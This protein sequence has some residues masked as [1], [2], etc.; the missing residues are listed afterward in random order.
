MISLPTQRWSTR[1]QGVS[2]IDFFKDEL[3]DDE[4][5]VL[6][7]AASLHV[8]YIAYGTP[9]G[10]TCLV[11]ETRWITQYALD[12]F[13][14]SLEGEWG[15][16]YPA[17]CPARILKLLTPIE[18]L[19]EDEYKARRAADWRARCEAELERRKK[20]PKVPRGALVRF[21]PP[22][23]TKSGQQLE[24]LRYRRHSSFEDPADRFTVWRVPIWRQ[25]N[26]EII[27]LPA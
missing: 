20:Q 19:F 24:I 9:A 26:F 5:V 17:K 14:Y 8:A 4:N 1:K 22:L 25:R 7:V 18:Q 13:S 23:K 12:E 2:A 21:D 6:D 11:A 10:V 15:S 3:D 27:E 16:P